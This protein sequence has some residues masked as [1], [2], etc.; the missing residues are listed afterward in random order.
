MLV[1]VENLATTKFD[2]LH[3]TS[4][5]DAVISLVVTKV[6]WFLFDMHETKVVI[7][8][9]TPNYQRERLDDWRG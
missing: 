2:T 8:L 4:C 9:A 1:N 5:V 3:Q 6:F 7:G